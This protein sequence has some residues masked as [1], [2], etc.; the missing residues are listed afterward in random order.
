MNSRSII[1]SAGEVCKYTFSLQILMSFFTCLLLF[2]RVVFPHTSLFPATAQ[3]NRF[4]DYWISLF[5][6]H[7]NHCDD[8]C[9]QQYT[10][11]LSEYILRFVNAYC[12]Y[13]TNLRF[14]LFHLH[15]KKWNCIMEMKS[16]SGRLFAFQ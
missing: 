11:A 14:C 15:Y 1:L 9:W 10:D 3:C 7:F 5:P 16:V 12:I 4:C 6:L 2:G 8:I 13:M